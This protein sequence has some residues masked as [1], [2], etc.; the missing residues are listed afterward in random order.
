MIHFKV[1]YASKA[2]LRYCFVKFTGQWLQSPQIKSGK[3]SSFRSMF[4]ELILHEPIKMLKKIK[5]TAKVKRRYYESLLRNPKLYYIF[6]D[7]FT[8]MKSVSSQR[9]LESARCAV[10]TFNSHQPLCR[11][12]LVTEI[13]LYHSVAAHAGPVPQALCGHQRSGLWRRLL[14][15]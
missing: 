5:A 1:S 6:N 11:T 10:Q 15:L 8:E 14:P 12:S 4:H 9:D 13:F 7:E 2:S 3:I